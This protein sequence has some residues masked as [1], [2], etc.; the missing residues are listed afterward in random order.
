[1]KKNSEHRK[2]L[3]ELF[4]AF[5]ILGRGNYVLMRD[6]KCNMV[7]FSPD[8]VE[9]FGLPGEYVPADQIDWTELIHPEDRFRYT[10]AHNKLVDGTSK[11]SASV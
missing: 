3:D 2:I 9:L 4:D 6:V 5:T 7:R 10:H 8:A 1:M 11:S